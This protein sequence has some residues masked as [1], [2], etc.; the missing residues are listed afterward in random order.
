M[1]AQDTDHTLSPT[2]E[3][4]SLGAAL[5]H[6]IR[7]VWP[8][9][10]H[11]ELL[12]DLGERKGWTEGDYQHRVAEVAVWLQDHLMLPP[13]FDRGHVAPFDLG[14]VKE[15]VAETGTR[16]VAGV[17]RWAVAVAPAVGASPKALVNSLAH[18]LRSD[19]SDH[20]WL[21]AVARVA[22]GAMAARQI[23]AWA[24]HRRTPQV[25]AEA[26]GGA[27]GRDLQDASDAMLVA[28]L[29]ALWQRRRPPSEARANRG[30]AVGR[31][32]TPKPVA[33]LGGALI[34]PRQ[35]GHLAGLALGTEQRGLLLTLQ[36][37]CALTAAHLAPHRARRSPRGAGGDGEQLLSA[38]QRALEAHAMVLGDSELAILRYRLERLRAWREQRIAEHNPLALGT[39]VETCRMLETVPVAGTSS[40]AP[41]R[42]CAS[43]PGLLMLLPLLRRRGFEIIP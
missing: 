31:R 15:L 19:R 6:V 28:S 30:K 42:V 11:L 3:Q 8:R 17:A 37:E 13:H 39:Y 24:Y 2:S 9:R 7:R 1:I 14:A 33:A 21:A 35:V 27:A 29:V 40:S 23:E 20:R 26:L 18:G 36:V 41:S 34:A 25:V 22:S 38:V 43:T 32:A 4:V 12:L 5:D 16:P 10:S